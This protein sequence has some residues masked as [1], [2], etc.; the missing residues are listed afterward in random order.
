MNLISPVNLYF[1]DSNHWYSLPKWAEFFIGV[2][3][4]L[5]CISKE[6]T[7][8]LTAIVVP[9]RAFGTAFVSLGMV[10]SDAAE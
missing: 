4:F 2:G 10:I 1:E 3:K 7:R 9:T 5:P 8:I 6:K